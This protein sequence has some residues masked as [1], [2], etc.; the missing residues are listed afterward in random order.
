GDIGDL[1]Q[2][3]TDLVS[4]A[5]Y[6]HLT[7]MLAPRPALLLYNERDDC[8]FVSERARPSVYEPVLPFY[9][10]F[11][12][13]RDF[14]YHENKDPGTHNYDQDNRQQFYHFILQQFFPGGEQNSEEFPSDAELFNP[15]QLQVGLPEA[16]ANFFTLAYER[17][18]SLP[19]HPAPTS[20]PLALQSWQGEAR[21]RL[22]D[23]LRLKSMAVS[24]AAIQR[25]KQVEQ[26]GGE[27]SE[28][29]TLEA[30]WYKLTIGGEWTVPAVVISEATPQ[31]TVVAFADGGHATAG[32][33]VREL[34]VKGSRVIVVDP[35][36]MGEC[37]PQ[38]VAP[39]QFAQMMGTVGERPLGIQVG[40]VSAVIQWACQ[41]YGT[42][43]VSIYGNGWTAG[44]VCLAAA[45]LNPERVSDV[46]VAGGL[47]SLKRL[48][49]DHLDYEQYP[50]LFCFGLLEQ[51]D[52]AELV[53]LCS[54]QK[55]EYRN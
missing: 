31:S 29:A 49:E 18:S 7:A 46:V 21:S 14:E 35:L 12:R 16:N 15:D 41:Q 39:W 37:I 17:L 36:F 44:I 55:V 53:A 3:P 19:K 26:S 28:E 22:R 40:Q 25:T 51:F 8:C 9:R 13:D 5:D 52:V 45:G 10:L 20:D 24:A 43:Q 1:E 27:G 32:K 4:I 6:P 50:T 38:G 48:I 11:G 54:P 23:V 33:W 2:N 47:S 34:L 42:E 30:T